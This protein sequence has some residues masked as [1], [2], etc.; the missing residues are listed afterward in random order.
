[1][2]ESGLLLAWLACSAGFAA[3][4]AAT[5]S[6]LMVPL[7][8]LS[9]SFASAGAFMLIGAIDDRASLWAVVAP[10]VLLC[11]GLAWVVSARARPGRSIAPAMLVAMI[12][13]VTPLLAIYAVVV[14]VCMNGA[15][16][17]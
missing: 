16:A 1:M 9:T 2:A 11:G 14:S 5:R 8:W 3:L 12:G 10:V 7:L 6:W 15:C 4:A 17:D 13:A